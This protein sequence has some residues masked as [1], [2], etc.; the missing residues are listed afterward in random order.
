MQLPSYQCGIR[1]LSPV[2]EGMKLWKMYVKELFGNFHPRAFY[3]ATFFF[4]I[5][6]R[7]VL[8]SYPYCMH[9]HRQTDG[10]QQRNKMRRV[11]CDGSWSTRPCAVTALSAGLRGS[12]VGA[13]DRQRSALCNVCVVQ[14]SRA[15][16][17]N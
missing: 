2:L 10:V 15:S 3:C 12:W 11:Q 9:L 14:N 13:T 8:P 6:W 16:P 7:S 4:C 1:G 5:L 17:T